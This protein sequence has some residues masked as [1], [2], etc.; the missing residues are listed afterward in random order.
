MFFIE[1]RLKTSE[2]TNVK[3]YCKSL[4]IDY[5]PL[6]QHRLN[7]HTVPSRIKGQIFKDETVLQSVVQVQ[8]SKERERES[9]NNLFRRNH[10]AK[11]ENDGEGGITPAS[12]IM[13][14]ES[15]I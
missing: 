10:N 9:R 15:N 4:V 6:W 5:G 12:S 1:N 3:R 8:K 11:L 7:E 2:R 13:E 14:S